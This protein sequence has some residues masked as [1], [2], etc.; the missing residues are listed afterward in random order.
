MNWKDIVGYEGY[1]Q[2]SD[3]G[4]IKSVGRI[5]YRKGHGGFKT[6]KEKVLPTYFDNNGYQ[7]AFLSKN[8]MRKTVKVHRLVAFAFIPVVDNKTYVNHKDGDKSNNKVDNLEWC[9]CSENIQ[10]ADKIGL[11]KC[12]SGENNPKSKK[13]IDTSTGIIYPSISQAAVK[14][15]VTLK[16]FNRWLNGK[17]RKSQFSIIS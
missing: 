5:V 14:N 10:H 12:A 4:Q 8:G 11:R 3:T 13:V 2:V 9:T 6:V 16:V 17:K 1:Y 15:N 7:I